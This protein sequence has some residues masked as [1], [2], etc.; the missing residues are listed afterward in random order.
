YAVYFDE[1]ALLTLGAA[2]EKR[3]RLS[4]AV[5]HPIVRRLET[6]AA[7]PLA[8]ALELRERHAD[9]LLALDERVTAIVTSLKERGI[10]S[11]YLRAFVV[12]RINPLRFVPRAGKGPGKGRGKG[13]E[14][15]PAR[16]PDWDATFEKLRRGA[17]KF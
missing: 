7:T 4:G 17:E 2:Y 13:T 15:A 6:F 5:F 8:R 10:Q 16:T 11:P 1:P 3:P 9:E 12:A 14:E